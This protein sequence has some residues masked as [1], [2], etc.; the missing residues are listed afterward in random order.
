MFYVSMCECA[1]NKINQRAVNQT[2]QI[3]YTCKVSKLLRYIA[4]G[5]G[6]KI[7]HT[8]PPEY[9]LCVTLFELLQLQLVAIQLKIFSAIFSTIRLH[10]KLTSTDYSFMPYDFAVL[11]LALLL[12]I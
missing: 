9:V 7:A 11:L 12:G 4:F 1:Y 10:L 2:S 3:I 8:A 6:K 5:Y